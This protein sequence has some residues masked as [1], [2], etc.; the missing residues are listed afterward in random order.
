MTR[1]IVDPDKAKLKKKKTEDQNVV[2]PITGL[3]WGQAS[4]ICM[5]LCFCNSEHSP[6]WTHPGL[7]IE[8]VKS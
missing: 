8:R 2:A 3:R 5:G 6:G 7:A 4:N 1:T